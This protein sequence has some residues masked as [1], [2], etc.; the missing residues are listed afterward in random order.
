MIV[1][2]REF[3]FGR[4]L[5]IEF[6]KGSIREENLVLTVEHAPEVDPNLYV[7]MDATVTDMPSPLAANKPGFQGTVTIYNP[8][9]EVLTIVAS[10]ATWLSD[11]ANEE[12]AVGT[13]LSNAQ[14]LGNAQS[15]IYKLGKIHRNNISHNTVSR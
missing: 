14:K 4:C 9:P 10:G 1:N 15:S 7:A 3:N 8:S 5:K 6:Y 11:F 13:K 12:K 2:G